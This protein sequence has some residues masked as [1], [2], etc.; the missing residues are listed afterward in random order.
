MRD[1]F[2]LCK[3]SSPMALSEPA[4]NVSPSTLARFILS[5]ILYHRVFCAFTSWCLN[6]HS[7]LPGRGF[8]LPQEAKACFSS[9]VSCFDISGKKY[10]PSYKF[11]W[12]VTP[13]AYLMLSVGGDSYICNQHPPPAV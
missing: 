11:P 13:P 9:Q 5:D 8:L 12:P 7:S 6:P 4:C 3:D 2:L 10:L 1:V